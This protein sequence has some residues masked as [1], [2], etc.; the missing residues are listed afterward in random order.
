MTSK[1]ASPAFWSVFTFNAED[2]GALLEV[3]KDDTLSV[4]STPRAKSCT[5]DCKLPPCAPGMLAYKDAPVSC[6][7]IQVHQ[8]LP[9]HRSRWR[10]VA[11]PCK[12]S[13]SMHGKARVVHVGARERQ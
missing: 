13:Y 8:L 4:I 12:V 1:F 11:A 3:S 7:G 9:Q 2:L 10:H 6:G 5:P